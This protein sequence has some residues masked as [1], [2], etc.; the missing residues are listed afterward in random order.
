MFLSVQTRVTWR[1]LLT[2]KKRASSLEDCG[3]LSDD[4]HSS[5][6]R[7]SSATSILLCIFYSQVS[8]YLI[9][10]SR[11]KIARPREKIPAGIGYISSHFYHVT[12]CDNFGSSVHGI[13]QI[14]RLEWIAISSSKSSWPRDQTRVSC[15]AGRFFIVWATRE[16]QQK[17]SFIILNL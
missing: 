8:F 1:P 13:L 2:R 9:S 10:L 14:R 6:W 15:I 11:P 16:A 12:S 17:Q 7:R 3:T 5:S 4:S